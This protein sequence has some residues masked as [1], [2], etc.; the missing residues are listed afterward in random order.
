MT[1]SEVPTFRLWERYSSLKKLKRI[2][3]WVIQAATKFR[4]KPV[5]NSKELTT[6]ELEAAE[7][8]IL[9]RAQHECWPEVWE[10]LDKQQQLLHGHL[11]IKYHLRIHDGL[12]RLRG[13]V[14]ENEVIPLRLS[15]T[16][17]RL[18]VSSA[19][20]EGHP[21]TSTLIRLLG[22]TS[23]IPR[24]KSYVKGVGRSCVTCQRMYAWPI[25]QPTGD[26][27]IDRTTPT[28]SFTKVGVDLTGSL[29]SPE[30]IRRNPCE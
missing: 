1:T 29:F 30:G 13:R 9:S 15:S 26:L 18:I 24:L 28:L 17:T 8:L 25:T 19:H 6:E 23:H 27:P 22:R 16:I 12:I 10:H 21:D 2:A 20:N 3:A 5:S 11:L 4:N 7:R 14:K